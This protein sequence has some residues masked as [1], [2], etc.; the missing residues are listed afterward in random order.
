MPR[1]IPPR[2]NPDV[3]GMISQLNDSYSHL[4]RLSAEFAETVDGMAP[5]R[6][7]RP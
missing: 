7:A 2:V 5:G 6:Q 1:H 3:P 4:V